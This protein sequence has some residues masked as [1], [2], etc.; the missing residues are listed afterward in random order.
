MGREAKGVS[1][2]RHQESGTRRAFAVV[3]AMSA[4][5]ISAERRAGCD[6]G[7]S[8]RSVGKSALDIAKI[9]DPATLGPIQA[10]TAARLKDLAEAASKDKTAAARLKPLRDALNER[11][12]WMDELRKALRDRRNAENPKVNPAREAAELKAEIERAQAGLEQ[13]SKR[14]DAL[15][16]EAFRNLATKPIDAALKAMKE[17]IDDVEE[18]LKDKREADDTEKTVSKDHP[19]KNADPLSA[20]RAEREKLVQG[21]AGLASRLRTREEALAAAQGSEERILARELLMNIQWETRVQVERLRVIDAL[22]DLETKRAALADLRRSARKASAA[23]ARKTLEIMQKRFRDLAS[24]QSRDLAR[25]SAEETERAR[26]SSDPV[27]RYR[28]RRKSELLDLRSE[29]LKDI[30]ALDAEPLLSLREQTEAADRAAEDFDA[31]R[32]LV[33]E[34]RSSPLVATRLNYVFRRLASERDAI[35]K[36]ELALAVREDVKR[37]NDLNEIEMDILNDER[38][39]RVQL[40]E[41]LEIVPPARHAELFKIAGKL[42]EEHRALLENRRAVLVKLAANAEATLRQVQRRVNVLDE[43]YAFLRTN[44]FWVRDQEPIGPEMIAQARMEVPRLVRAV[45]RV[46]RECGNPTAWQRRLSPDFSLAAI[47]LTVLPWPIVR[48][49]ALLR[50]RLVGEP[51]A[52]QEPAEQASAGE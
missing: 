42:E 27:E 23:L 49:R 8:S 6:E 43:E 9:A 19:S 17:A 12:A 11:L 20:L 3:C 30:Q 5:V 32:R 48:V 38:D 29:L 47:A 52:L 35:V 44:I 41:L 28:S 1:M 26:A 14:P 46:S 25:A 18:E 13:A 2:S 16:P 15:L 4:F 40:D 10:E 21:R 24:R 39:D 51:R 36:R 37:D 22:I 45:A 50:G 34:G 7:S 31:L 33:R